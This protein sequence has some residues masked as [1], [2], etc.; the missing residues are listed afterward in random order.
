MHHHIVHALRLVGLGAKCFTG[1]TRS[2]SSVQ[3]QAFRTLGLPSPLPL[4]LQRP[5]RAGAHTCRE[6]HLPST[7]EGLVCFAIVSGIPG[8][9][10]IASLGFLAWI[11]SSSANL[12]LGHD[13]M[14]RPL[15]RLSSV[16]DP[17]STDVTSGSEWLLI[18]L[19]CQRLRR[20]SN[21]LRLSRPQ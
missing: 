14:S 21:C 12:N 16:V 18:I 9:M 17:I 10:S 5:S 20:S 8:R 2:V 15:T 13:N 4:A 3:C 7:L 6:C 19:K 1:H 11:N